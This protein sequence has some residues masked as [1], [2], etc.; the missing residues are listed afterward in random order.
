MEKIHHML[1]SLD[2]LYL[3]ILGESS[4]RIILLDQPEFVEVIFPRAKHDIHWLNGLYIVSKEN[5]VFHFYQTN[6]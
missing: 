6:R 4:H 5:H 1:H 2:I 3:D